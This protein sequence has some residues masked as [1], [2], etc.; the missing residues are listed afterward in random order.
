MT[1]QESRLYN[2]FFPFS[3]S[4]DASPAR[5]HHKWYTSLATSVNEIWGANF[6]IGRISSIWENPFRDA[7]GK[8]Q[9]AKAAQGVGVSRPDKM[10]GSSVKT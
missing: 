6:A 2:V 1:I 5:R 9:V 7:F 8:N 4:V 10:T 3:R